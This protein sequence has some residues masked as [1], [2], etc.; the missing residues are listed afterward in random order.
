LNS[1]MQMIE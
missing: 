1:P